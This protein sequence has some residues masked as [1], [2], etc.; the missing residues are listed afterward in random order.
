MQQV[1]LIISEKFS[2]LPCCAHL[3]TPAPSFTKLATA[4][5]VDLLLALAWD[6]DQGPRGRPRFDLS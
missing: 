2:I 1:R 6:N 4:A 3:F 5:T